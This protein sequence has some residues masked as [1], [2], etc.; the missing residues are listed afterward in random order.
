[1]K[2]CSI[3]K[4]WKF[5]HAPGHAAWEERRKQREG[6]SNPQAKLADAGEV[7]PT[8]EETGEHDYIPFQ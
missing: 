6:T 1:M 8:D 3:C 5:H 4:R 7:P 2:Y